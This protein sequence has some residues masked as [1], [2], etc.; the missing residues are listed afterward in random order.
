MEKTI[1]YMVRHGESEAN[2]RDAYLGFY[3]LPLTDV[4]RKQAEMAAEFVQTLGADGIYASDLSRAR[5]T[6][7]A[8]AKRLGLPVRACP[9]VREMYM[10][11]WEDMTFD[12]VR[13]GYEALFRIWTN[14]F[15]NGVTPGGETVPQLQARVLA[16]MTKIAEENKGKRILVF[17]H[18]TP[19]RA[20][21]AHG[22]GVSIGSIP[23]PSNAS[24][25]TLEYENGRF[26]C[27]QYS[28][29]DFMGALVTRLPDDI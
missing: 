7:F 5:N 20:M 27:P 16:A 21:A 29:D 26:T 15:E 10:G 2:R 14:D 23:W 25:T 22:M 3:D 17:S 11:I 9:Q 1:L 8:T 6:A 19:I 24:V 28:R 4:G 18:G 13:S 12:R